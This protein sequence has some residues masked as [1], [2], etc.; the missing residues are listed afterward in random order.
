MSVKIV[1]S[2]LFLAHRLAQAQ[3]IS[4][5]GGQS[6]YLNRVMRLREGASVPVFNGRDGEW[7]A[8]LQHGGIVLKCT[9][10]IRRQVDCPDVWLLMTPLRQSRTEFA[11][12]KAVEL[13]VRRICFVSTKRT[14][15]RKINLPRLRSIAIEAAEQ[16]GGMN[17]PHIEDVRALFSV[18]QTWPSHRTLQFCDEETVG[19]RE[20]VSIQAE[21]SASA[22]L[23]GPEGGFTD[24]ERQQIDALE[25]SVRVGLG[26]R[27]LRAET[28]VIAALALNNIDNGVYSTTS[29][30]DSA[31]M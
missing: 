18:L 25:F 15:L 21:P 17:V 14:V 8:E 7:L 24:R 23:V 11:V 20:V 16:C 5:D 10:Q 29:A 22:V 1:K 13:G 27:V 19:E 9:S 3:C 4:L 30:S 12:E 28:A 6:R 26:C 2:R 31:K